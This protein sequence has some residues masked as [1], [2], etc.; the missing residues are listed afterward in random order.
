MTEAMREKA[1]A[2][3]VLAILSGLLVTILALQGLASVK[4]GGFEAFAQTPAT[5][6]PG[7]PTI[8]IIN[9]DES[10]SDEISA[11]SDTVDNAYH[12]V[13]WVANLPSSASVQFKYIPE[14]TGRETTVIC[15][16]TG[17]ETA[18]QVGTD[19]F[20]CRWNLTG[21]SAGA[22]T[23]RAILF[24]G[25]TSV[26]Q[27]DEPVTVDPEGQTLEI[28]YPTNGGEVGFYTRAGGISSAMIDVRTS[29]PGTPADDEGTE[30]VDVYYSTSPPGTEPAFIPC[31]N[32][33]TTGGTQDSIR[34]DLAE[35]DPDTAA[36]ENDEP[37]EVT[38]IAAVPI[39]TD[40]G[41]IPAPP[42]G[43][44][45]D[46]AADIDA[47]DAHR[48]FGYEQDP[49]AVLLAPQT[50]QKNA[51]QC[52]DPIVA[53]VIDTK[54]RI[55]V[56]ANVD[57]HAQG[58]T[59]NVSF[60]GVP[61]DDGPTSASKPPEGHTV[62]PAVDCETAT[63]T[64]PP[65]FDGEQGDHDR[66]DA[67]VKHIESVD[68]GTSEDG[69]F[70][71]KLYSPNAGATQYTVW[72]DEDNNDQYC[73]AEAAGHGSVG[74]STTAPSPTGVTAEQTTCPK[75]S[76]GQTATPGV[77]AT[78]TATATPTSTSTATPTNTATSSGPTT[79]RTV[80]MSVD[81]SSV[82]AGR[83]VTFSG[84]ILSGDQSCTDNEFVQI[85]RRVFGTTTY[86]DILTTASD[87][88]GRF[89]FTRRVVKSADYTATAT[90]H[91]QCRDATSGEVTVE[92]KVRMQIVVSDKTP[93]RG[94][95]IKIKSSVR[96][97]HD[98]TT[99]LLQRK[100]GRRWVTV[101]RDKINR[102]SV[103]SFVVRAN[104]RQRTFRTKWKS[105]DAEH[106]T[107]TSTKRTIRT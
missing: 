61:E 105:Q 3:R 7:S 47:A 92:V 41:P 45:P 77:T 59:D 1:S 30:E 76:P 16:E 67:D 50:Q 94:D 100:K 78:P 19:T 44:D 40:E 31:G 102:R 90:A 39:D 37:S 84:Q 9:P 97:Q 99:L 85:R 89:T 69:R 104:F 73:S 51:G 11:K 21:V 66:I 56:G 54:N 32:D 6:T 81:K 52:S 74:W 101:D 2:R 34:C 35:D 33:T 23:V 4:P 27:D 72:V 8:K 57:V 93:D 64:T 95:R 91:D 65:E 5:P 14:D 55:V 13:A 58:P 26:S 80:T 15:Q 29:A 88:Q 53:T 42:A 28:L 36:N 86:E 12:L 46:A 18:R 98:R 82:V 83:K 38:A 87:A 71:F 60:D 43:P 48:A 25:T 17:N 63:A 107:N 20:E 10:T 79:N 22:G 103:G 49:N 70:S 96:P 62:E 68:E 106:A 75:P 24:S